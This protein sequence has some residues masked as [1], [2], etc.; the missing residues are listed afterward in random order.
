MRV[1]EDQCRADSTSHMPELARYIRV[2]QLHSLAKGC[3]VP[4]VQA[5]ICELSIDYCWTA[6][7]STSVWSKSIDGGSA[8][9]ST[10][11]QLTGLLRR[12]SNQTG[13]STEGQS[14]C[15][16]VECWQVRRQ[17]TRK[18]LSI[19]MRRIVG[20][21]VQ[22]CLPSSVKRDIQPLTSVTN[23]SP[24]EDSDTLHISS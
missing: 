7:M 14:C 2:I 15:H 21:S 12:L 20:T 24:P 23:S 22:A 11:A 4:G 5:D 8:I 13:Y 17:T 6:V 19:R 16:W 3:I 9:P 1:K 10:F 18:M